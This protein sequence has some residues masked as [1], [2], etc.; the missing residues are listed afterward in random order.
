M[1]KTP[2]Q[3][4]PSLSLGLTTAKLLYF[5]SEP[6][7]EFPAFT[8]SC[9]E[10]H[11]TGGDPMRILIMLAIISAFIVTFTLAAD[12]PDAWPRWRGPYE[13][14]VAR[15]D[16][17][18]QWSDTEHIAWK[19]DVPGRG[20]SSPVIWG[21][22]IFLTTA[23]SSVPIP[24]TSSAPAQGA[25]PQM[26]AGGSQRGPGGTARQ[27]GPQEQGG[28]P[29]GDQQGQRGPA[30]GDQQR[31]GGPP[32]S[33]SAQLFEHKFM[34]I[35]Y[36]RHTGKKLWERVAK[37]ATPHE[38]YHSQLGSFASG[39]P[40]V[41]AKHVIVSFGSRGVYCYTHNGN[42]VWQKDFGV[43]MTIRMSFG[44]GTSPALDGNTVVLLYDFEGDS[45]IVALDKNT[46]RELWRK[47]RPQGSAMGTAWASPVITTV[48]G[49]K[50][51]IV[52]ATKFVAGYDLKTGQVI[53]RATGLGAN[54]IPMPIVSDGIVWVMSGYQNPNGMAIRL[55]REGDLTGTDAIL[56]QNNKGNSYVPSPVL[57]DGKLYILADAGMLSCFDFK[58][59][60]AYYTQTRLPKT[61]DFKASLVAANGKL[62]ASSLDGD[63][64]VIQAGEKFEV[65]AT[66]TLVDQQFIASPAI[67]GGA[68]Y[69]R[70]QNTLFCIK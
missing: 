61:Y 31:Q 68:I 2:A 49:K 19:V 67:A 3:G 26:P 8:N 36:N 58:T 4:I 39:S 37:V 13:T 21:D 51:V 7:K 57:Y 22:K 28:P 69:L 47:E 5:A 17:P 33:S 10:W 16:A 18:L 65:L 14:G 43:K 24:T 45:F 6:N 50:Q 30:A 56:W 52:A 66:N 46:G 29:Q 42:L 23:V 63:V 34:V 53:W 27:G 48:N 38:G 59:G 15:G 54:A 11:F 20:E 64:V 12:G 40:V 1:S 41:D 32:F 25:P 35:A 60:K 55:G 70:G 62:Y 44:E 9:V